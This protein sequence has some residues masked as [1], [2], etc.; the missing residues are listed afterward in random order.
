[1][2]RPELF[3]GAILVELNIGVPVIAKVGRSYVRPGGLF[4]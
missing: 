1:M 4:R 3:V 2:M